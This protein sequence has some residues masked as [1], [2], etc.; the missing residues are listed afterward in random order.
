[1]TELYTRYPA[2]L[3]CKEDI[4]KASA[5]LLECAQNGGKNQ[6]GFSSKNQIDERESIYRSSITQI[7]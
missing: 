4:E 6:H 5:L 2:L 1:M 7:F 3:G